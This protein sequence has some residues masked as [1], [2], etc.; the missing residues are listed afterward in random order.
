MTARA[1][2]PR[3]STRSAFALHGEAS[4]GRGRSGC[5]ARPAQDASAGDRDRQGV[6][7]VVAAGAVE[8]PAE[9]GRA[10]PMLKPSEPPSAVDLQQ[11]A[12]EHHR[13]RQRQHPEED[14]AVAREQRRERRRRRAPRRRRRRA[15]SG[16]E[17]LGDAEPVDGERDGVAADREEQALAERAPRRRASG[18]TMPSETRPCD[19]AMR[20]RGTA[21]SSGRTRP[22]GAES[23]QRRAP[24]DGGEREAARGILR[25]SAPPRA[26]TG[27]R[28]GTISTAAMTR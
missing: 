10:R 27:L 17:R 25:S 16:S 8:A 7:G 21:A 4:P 15:G 6:Q 3:Y 2:A 19:A 26:G 5:R 28:A 14:A 22:S 11:H 9:Q 12:V 23:G 1:E 20:Q 18:S 13:E 24:A